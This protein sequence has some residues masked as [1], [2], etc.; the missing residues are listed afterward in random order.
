MRGIFLPVGSSGL[1][2]VLSLPP[3]GSI[4][5]SVIFHNILLKMTSYN[6]YPNLP[7]AP[8]QSPDN[9]PWSSQVASE[10]QGPSRAYHLNVV[11]AKRQRLINKEVMFKKKYEK[12]TKI[13][14]LLT[15]SNTCSSRISIATGIS[16]VQH[17]LHSSVCL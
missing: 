6:T 2:S 14:N 12:Y 10:E 9:P 4:S 5:M 13:L 3:N 17:S 16:S 11:Q 8:P 15:W 1:D 7:S